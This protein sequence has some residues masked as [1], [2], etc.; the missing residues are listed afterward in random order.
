MNNLDLELEYDLIEQN[1]AD[2]ISSNDIQNDILN[3]VKLTEN[4]YLYTLTSEQIF[5]TNALEEF[6]SLARKIF[7]YVNGHSEY[8]IFMVG[9]IKCMRHQEGLDKRLLSYCLLD[10]LSEYY[11]DL[12]NEL[13]STF[14]K[15]IGCNK[16][17]GCWKDLKYFYAFACKIGKEYTSSVVEYSIKL[18][19]EQLKQ[20][21]LEDINISN[22]AKWIPREKTKYKKLYERLVVNY[23]KDHDYFKY[24][25]SFRK[26]QKNKAM[27]KAKMEYRKNLSKLNKQLD[28]V[29]IKQCSKQWQKINPHTQTYRTLELQINA[30]LNLSRSN[31]KIR[32]ASGDRIICSQ[33]FIDANTNIDTD[34]NKDANTNTNLNKI[35][36]FNE[37]F[38]LISKYANL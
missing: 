8:L 13:F 26:E 14:V 30:F 31:N 20:D 38:N 7:N 19:N 37:L 23:F 35:T 5:N 17:I 34:K 24:A 12:A 11:P 29:Q 28:T 33:N 18:A 22:V 9:L 32:Y 21:L 3:L 6:D 4:K 2:I 25:G 1:D 16:S 10:I 36:T 15:S 27:N